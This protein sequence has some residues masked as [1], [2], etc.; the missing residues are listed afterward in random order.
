MADHRDLLEECKDWLG[1]QESEE[2]EPPRQPSRGRVSPAL[3]QRRS[4]RLSE[5]EQDLPESRYAW[6]FV[7]EEKDWDYH[8]D[9]FHIVGPE[10]DDIPIEF[11]EVSR[12]RLE[13]ISLFLQS[14]QGKKLLVVV[15]RWLSSFR[16]SLERFQILNKR[17]LLLA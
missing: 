14:H 11:R 3:A 9:G 8:K 15:Y 12:P 17:T 7:R 13:E 5:V 4:P 1:E 10:P 2:E 16:F 6:Q